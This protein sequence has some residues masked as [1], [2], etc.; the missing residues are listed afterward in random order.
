MLYPYATKTR[1]VSLLKELGYNVPKLKETYFDKISHAFWLEWLDSDR[2]YHKAYYSSC[3]G[4]PIFSVDSKF[5]E[6][7]LQQIVA[8][9]MYKE[10]PD[11]V[12]V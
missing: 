6:I 8:L 4:R 7:S 12:K 2:A 9:G 3:L 11:K 1:M 5:V 10:V